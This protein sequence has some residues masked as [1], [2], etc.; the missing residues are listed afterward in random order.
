MRCYDATLDVC[1]QCRRDV[2]DCECSAE[3]DPPAERAT[4][5]SALCTIAIYLAIYSA[6]IAIYLFAEE[7]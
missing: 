3:G 2:P 7:L 1:F 4:L 6:G 5:I